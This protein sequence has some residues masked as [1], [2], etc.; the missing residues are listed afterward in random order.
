MEETLV[1]D[2]RGLLVVTD[3][4][5]DGDAI[6]V[7]LTPLSNRLLSPPTTSSGIARKDGETGNCSNT[8]E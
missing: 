6:G 2:V 5:I 4:V 8:G 1:I 7:T 3:V